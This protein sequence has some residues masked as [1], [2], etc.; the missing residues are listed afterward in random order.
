MAATVASLA[1]H[2]LARYPPI[3]SLGLSLDGAGIRVESNDNGL[4]LHLRRYFAPF[5][6]DDAASDITVCALSTPG[7]DL[8]LTFRDWPREPGKTRRKDAHAELPDGRAVLKVR[9]GMQFL[10]GEGTRLAFGPCL[11]NA[12]QVVNF[13]VSQYIG[14]LLDR[15]WLL[16][17]AAGVTR[18][19]GGLGLAGLSG[20]GKSSLMLHLLSAGLGFAS[21]DRLLLQRDNGLVR[22]RG[23]P[24]MPRVN[25]GTLL[26]QPRLEPILPASRR[27][28]L[29]ALS[30]DELW[31]LEEK[32]DVPV[33]E[34]YPDSA[35]RLSA[36]LEAVAI[37]AWDPGG[38]GP[39]VLEEVD[40]AER[41]D[42]LGALMKGTGPFYLPTPAG[43]GQP[44]SGP[45]LQ[46][47]RD[48]RAVA[49][50]GG[51]DF[52]AAARACLDLLG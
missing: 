51:V 28:A 18:R 15:G 4:L 42:L 43:A 41:G 36:R 46:A 13:V 12:N 37:L 14:H 20:R 33:H 32:Y 30:R 23:V 19:G 5:V 16:A 50:R 52:E 7:L 34:I 31:H 47:L 11:E 24:K 48:V 6:D 35:L 21:N 29:S 39:T 2:I 45:Y 27:G 26:S 44:R 38:A 1:G 17:H 25:P 22:M 9:T 40:L 49:I 8:G 3:A 10:M